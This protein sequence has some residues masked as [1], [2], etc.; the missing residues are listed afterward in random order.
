VSINGNRMIAR[1]EDSS[2]IPIIGLTHKWSTKEYQ[3][4]FS[5]SNL[6][7]PE[8]KKISRYYNYLN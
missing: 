8:C 3:R 6:K 4:T 1:F 7:S 5:Q 2:A